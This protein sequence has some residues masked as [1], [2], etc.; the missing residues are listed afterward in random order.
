[1]CKKWQLFILASTLFLNCRPSEKNVAHTSPEQTS[2][3]I[4]IISSNKRIQETFD[5][6]KTKALSFVQT[7]KKG[8]VDIS[9][10]NSESS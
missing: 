2:Q 6:A 8:P 10:R 4:E 1:M 3:E 5:W 7:R 9:E